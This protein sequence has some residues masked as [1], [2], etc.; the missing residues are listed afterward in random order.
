MTT[1]DKGTTVDSSNLQLGERILMDFDFQNVTSIRGFTSTLT[2][3]CAKT[4]ML[5][6]FTNAPKRDPVRMT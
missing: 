5:Y 2:V 6:V 3:V 1:I 4:I